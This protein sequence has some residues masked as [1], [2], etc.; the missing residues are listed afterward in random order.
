MKTKTRAPDAN[1]FY[2]ALTPGP[3]ASIRARDAVLRRFR[4]LADET[5]GELAAVVSELVD[6]SVDRGPGRPITVA[7]LRSDDTLR[8]EVGDHD[9]FVPFEIPLRG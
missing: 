5:R 4:A 3:G 9:G 8:G 6:R 7:V 1:E 2:L